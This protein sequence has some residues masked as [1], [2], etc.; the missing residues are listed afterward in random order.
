MRWLQ[1]IFITSS[2]AAAE[3]TSKGVLAVC[4]CSVVAG[5]MLDLTAT[6]HVTGAAS[7]DSLCLMFLAATAYFT[8]QVEDMERDRT[9]DEDLGLEER[10]KQEQAATVTG[11][12]LLE[13]DSFVPPL[14]PI[15]MTVDNL[16]QGPFLTQPRRL[17]IAVVDDYG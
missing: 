16:E 14:G 4:L 1:L 12:E 17:V 7:L 10:G 13:E 9:A 6:G 11:A 8:W 3:T 2:M 5:L 15:A